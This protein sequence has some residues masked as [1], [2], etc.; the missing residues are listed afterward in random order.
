MILLTI[1]ASV[2]HNLSTVNYVNS[3]IYDQT[4]SSESYLT[5]LALIAIS[6]S[7]Y[8]PYSIFI[9][10]IFWCILNFFDTNKLHVLSCL[11]LCTRI[12]ISLSCLWD[13]KASISP[14]VTLLC[15]T[16]AV[17]SY[18]QFW[19]THQLSEY[20]PHRGTCESFKYS[21]RY[22]DVHP[23]SWQNVLITSQFSLSYVHRLLI[24]SYLQHTLSILLM[25]DTISCSNCL[26][27]PT[28]RCLHC[29][30]EAFWVN[31]IC[32]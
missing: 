18:S 7:L 26:N 29:A 23:Y 24:E 20:W 19:L 28:W 27:F 32:C 30:P 8:Q 22:R 25:N 5:W 13:F 3:V 9:F 16:L 31:S 10:V 4:I 14:T 2:H 15:S 1:H 21:C 11:C 17:S 6:D 12:M